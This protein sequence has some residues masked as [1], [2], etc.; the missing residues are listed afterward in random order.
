VT[1]SQPLHPHLSNNHPKNPCQTHLP[2]QNM[3]DFWSTSDLQAHTSVYLFIQDLNDPKT[4]A[5]QQQGITI[6][7]PHN[8]YVDVVN[9]NLSQSV[10]S[11]SMA[12]GLYDL[13]LYHSTFQHE[14]G[15]TTVVFRT[16]SSARNTNL[17]WTRADIPFSQHYAGLKMDHTTRLVLRSMHDSL[18]YEYDL[19]VII[20]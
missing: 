5:Y 6:S 1:N 17:L 12:L 7:L 11:M 19:G 10:L 8:T 15:D 18:L 16:R 2:S 4:Y 3:S 14:S 13:P 20:I 9:L